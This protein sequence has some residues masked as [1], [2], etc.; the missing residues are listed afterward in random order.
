MKRILSL[1]LTLVLVLG[2]ISGCGSNNNAAD[3]NNQQSNSSTAGNTADSTSGESSNEP[4]RDTVNLSINMAWTSCDPFSTQNIQDKIIWWQ[5]YEGLMFWNELTGEIDPCLAT[6]YDVSEDGLTYTFHLRDDVYFHNGEKMTADDVVFS[7]HRAM[8][9][10]LMMSN[11]TTNISEVA[12]VDETTVQVELTTSYAPFLLNCCY[13]FI[14]NE[15]EVTEQGDQFG[16]EISTAGTGPYKLTYLDNDTKI[17]LEA[18]DQYYRG[19]ASIKNVN[20]YPVTDSAAGLI[21][22]ESGDLDWYAAGVMDAQRIEMEGKFSVEMMGANH[23][24]YFAVNPNCD[25]ETLANEKIRQAMCYAVNRDEMNMAAFEGAAV[26]ALYMFNPNWNVG[27]PEGD[28]VFEYNPEKAKELLAEAGYP[29]GVNCGKILCFKG[30]HFETCATMLQAQLAAV[31]IQT[32][33]EW[34]EQSIVTSA[35]RSKDYQIIVCGFNCLGDYGDFRQRYYSEL[36]TGIINLT[37]TEYD[38][39]YVDKLA[40]ESA[41][42]ADPAKRLELTK[43][44]NDYLAS[45]AML[46][47]LL[48]KAVAFVW[49]KDLT[50]VNRPINPIIYDWSWN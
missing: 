20:F 18:F 28:V 6:S 8:D 47:P 4:S 36:T 3:E 34:A 17:T 49:N 26:S 31:G 25:V 2:L 29:D 5:M 41:A 33:L 40:D 13:I 27:A 1:A 48:H 46:N 50:V 15:K 23:I 35:A 7:F 24:T 30:S 10:N 21:S 42:C 32:E 12:A 37:D 39:T 43:E 44:L 16:I 11:F 22:F 14:L 19:E 45:T 38:H 9:P